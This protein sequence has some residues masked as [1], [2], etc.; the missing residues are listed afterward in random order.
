MRY[1][2]AIVLVL[3]AIVVTACSSGPGTPTPTPL[4]RATWTP[5]VSRST[6][7][8]LA[9]AQPSASLATSVAPTPVPATPRPSPTIPPGLYVTSLRIDPNPPTRGSDLVFHATFL[10]TTGTVQNFKWLV[11]IYRPETPTR[12]YSETTLTMSSI[13]VGT[14][15]FKS[16]GAWKLP[17]GGPCENFFARVAWFDENNKAINFTKPDSQL[18]SQDFSVCAPGDLPPAPPPPTATPTRTPTFAPGVFALDLRTE[19][20]PATRGSDLKFYVTFVNTTGSPQTTRWNVYLF[21]PGDRNS[22]GE[23]TQTTTTLANG[24]NEYPSL[25]V[26]KLPLGGPCE[27]FVARVGWFD[28]ENK[29][30][31]FVKFENQTFEKPFAVCP[32]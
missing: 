28:N 13:P 1:L 3:F 7:P 11:Y 22:Y 31:M 25:G 19:P 2:T 30:K 20:N 24:I 5:T 23:V 6:S 12:S 9:L 16:L 17:L 14:S 32:P 21:K 10:N 26:W 15:E 8:T 29:V 18:F 27:D 4:P